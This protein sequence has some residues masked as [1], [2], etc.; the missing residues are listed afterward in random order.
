M[1]DEI[2]ICATGNEFFTEGIR[3]IVPVTRQII[4][5]SSK[6]ILIT[7]YS[8]GRMDEKIEKILV[9]KLMEGKN[10]TLIVNKYHGQELRPTFLDEMNPDFPNLKIYD[11]DSGSD[12]IDLH[13]KDLT[14]I[15]EAADSLG[16]PIP[17]TSIVQQFFTSLQQRDRGNYD[18]SGLI[19]FFEDL[20]C[21][22][23]R[24][25]S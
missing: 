8:F 9:E 16:V 10:L 1:D 3:Y 6:E 4:S 20:A 18:H 15:H 13:A 19:T 21:T 23:V 11:F 25:K 2:E 14:L 7:V 12:K 17:T 24:Q 5:S 22:K